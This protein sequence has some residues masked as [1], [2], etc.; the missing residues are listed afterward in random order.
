VVAGVVRA[1]LPT[2]DFTLAWS[3]SIEHTRWT[4]RYSVDRGRMLLVSARVE[5]SGAGMEAG[6][7]AQF[8][9]SGWV[10]RPKLASL[11]EVALAVSPYAADYTLCAGDRCRPLH[12]WAHMD[13]T[14][15]GVVHLRPC[16][17]AQARPDA[18]GG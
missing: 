2:A 6:D 13:A 5:G 4:E 12:A 14:S 9:G 16:D 11:P 10:W 15:I 18:A 8:D 7:G 3:H 17:G 1:A